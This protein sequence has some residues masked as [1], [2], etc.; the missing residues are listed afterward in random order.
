MIDGA[1]RD[2][3]IAQDKR[4]AELIKPL[5]VGRDIRKW[6]VDYKDKWLIF[7]RRGTDIEKYPAIKKYLSQWKAQ[8]TPKTVGA[9]IGRKPGSYKW[10]EIQDDVAYF[11]QFDKPKI[12]FPDLALAPRFSFDEREFF[13]N[14]TTF[15][16]PID[17]TFLLGVLNSHPFEDRFREVSP[18]ARG[19]YLRFKRA[20]L[21]QLPIPTPAPSDRV[22]IEELVTSCLGKRGVGCEAEEAEI[23][24]RVTK[25]YGLG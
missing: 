18:I 23:N 10:F 8:L 24:A 17:D 7:T 16:I 22:A 5:A 25:L 14:D 19:G 13:F 20:Y 2:K 9:T 12:V 4:S 21:E 15:I 1:T 11:A 3:L 6:S